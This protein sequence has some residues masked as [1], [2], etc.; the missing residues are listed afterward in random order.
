M[1][2][3]TTLGRRER[4]AGII[5]STQFPDLFSPRVMHCNAIAVMLQRERYKTMP[6]TQ[7]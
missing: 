7:P 4:S 5:I 6:T 3:Y 2:E 1:D